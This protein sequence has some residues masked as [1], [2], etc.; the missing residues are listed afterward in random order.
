VG[1]ACQCLTLLAGQRASMA[2]AGAYRLADELHR[3]NGDYPSAFPA[4]QRRLQ[5]EIVRRQAEARGL[6]KS[7]VPDNSFSIFVT[8][9]ILNVLF[10][11][12]FRSLFRNSIGAKSIIP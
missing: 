11:P 12:G 5:P 10:L 4:Y 2:M 9:L 1:D 7:F 6:A 8:H 3:A